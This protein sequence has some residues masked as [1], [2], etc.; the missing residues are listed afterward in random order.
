MRLI[1]VADVGNAINPAI[2]ETQLIRRRDHADRLHACPRRCCSTTARSPT[3]RSP[4]TRFPGF[5]DMPL[6]MANEIV[7]TDPARTGRSAPR[8]SARV[9][10]FGVS[11]AIANAIDDAVGVRSHRDAAQR[12]SGVPRAARRSR[13]AA[14][15]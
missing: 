2:V 4:T 8:A 12:R 7:D 15:G 9:A 6:D 13:Q 3:P 1:N 10:T 14:W 5:L 11:P